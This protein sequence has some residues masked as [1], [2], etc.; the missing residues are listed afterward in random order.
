VIYTAASSEP[1]PVQAAVVQLSWV[2]PAVDLPAV[3]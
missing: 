1:T 2:P 3:H